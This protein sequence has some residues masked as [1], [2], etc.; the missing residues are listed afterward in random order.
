MDNFYRA[1][2]TVTKAATTH[3]RYWEFILVLHMVADGEGSRCQFGQ[4]RSLADPLMHRLQP[5][6]PEWT[7]R[8][9]GNLLAKVEPESQNSGSAEL[10]DGPFSAAPS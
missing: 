1:V 2:M 5:R 6:G 4:T 10:L 7:P 8:V 3:N 9:G